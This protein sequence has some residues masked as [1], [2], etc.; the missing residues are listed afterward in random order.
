MTVAVVFTYSADGH[1][2]IIAC[3]DVAHK[4]DIRAAT[5]AA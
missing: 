1:F 5:G 2:H 3:A 4:Q